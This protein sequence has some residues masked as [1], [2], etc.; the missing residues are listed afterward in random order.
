MI[1]LWSYVN[2]KRKNYIYK[3]KYTHL[4]DY[5]TVDLNHFAPDGPSLL[6]KI[7]FAELCRTPCF[8]FPALAEY[9]ANCQSTYVRLHIRIW[10]FLLPAFVL[11]DLHQS[12]PTPKLW[13]NG[14]PPA[15]PS[16]LETSS[17]SL[18]HPG[19]LDFKTKLSFGK[20]LRNNCPG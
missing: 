4:Y 2:E 10:R 11:A 9:Q 12:V 5:T 8:T 7:A 19:H 20:L 6:R 1:H 18:G 17:H 15:W 16:Y 13:T 3:Y 14:S